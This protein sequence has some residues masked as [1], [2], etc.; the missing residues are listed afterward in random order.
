MPFLWLDVTEIDARMTDGT[1]LACALV[2]LHLRAG[3][4]PL[5]LCW[6]L[7][8]LVLQAFK[9]VQ[10]AKREAKWCLSFFL[11]VCVLR[12][13]RLVLGLRM[14]LRLYIRVCVEI[15]GLGFWVRM[16][17]QRLSSSRPALCCWRL[18]R[19]EALLA[20]GDFGRLPPSCRPDS[21]RGNWRRW[22]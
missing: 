7:A 19:E 11:A 14:E 4:A 16:L 20:V 2:S 18:F 13:C 5:A 6:Q 9:A 3:A 22:S 15:G 8:H 12:R 1:R 17:I 21:T 10:P